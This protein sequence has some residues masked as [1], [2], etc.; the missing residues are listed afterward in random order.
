MPMTIEPE[1]IGDLDESLLEQW[2]RRKWR[3]S[4]IICRRSWI[5]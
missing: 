3:I 4:R 2:I 1:D 5:R